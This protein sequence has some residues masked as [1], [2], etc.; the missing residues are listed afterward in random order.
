M[1]LNF[2]F[3]VYHT[4]R[5][6]ERITRIYLY[7]IYIHIFMPF[8]LFLGNISFNELECKNCSFSLPYCGLPRQ[9]KKIKTKM[10]HFQIWK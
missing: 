5:N 7:S 10:L 4:K 9:N 1:L 6:F 8:F 3:F 2:F